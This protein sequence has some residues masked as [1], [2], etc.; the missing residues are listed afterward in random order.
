LRATEQGRF[1]DAGSEG[2]WRR[3]CNVKVIVSHSRKSADGKV[4]LID[5][6]LIIDKLSSLPNGK[7]KAVVGK[8]TSHG[9]YL[10]RR[11][12]GNYRLWNWHLEKFGPD[13]GGSLADPVGW[14]VDSA[15]WDEPFLLLSNFDQGKGI[16]KLLI[17]TDPPTLEKQSVHWQFF[18]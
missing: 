3:R 14:F 18:Y 7:E 11:E 8:W 12:S 15:N 17:D 5:S 1:F 13:R 9:K 16:G 10:G 2:Y 6:T 4:T